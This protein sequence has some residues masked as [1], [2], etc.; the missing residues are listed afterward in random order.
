MH[1]GD[2]IDRDWKSF[3]VVV[4][5][6]DQLKAPHYHVLGNHDFSVAENKKVEVPKRLGLTSRYIALSV[7]RGA[8]LP[9]TE[10]TLVFT[11]IPK[12]V[13]ST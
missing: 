2:F 11:R 6:Y 10:M 1:L 3:D 8:L 4:P 9:W 7:A 12:G 13:I 5:I